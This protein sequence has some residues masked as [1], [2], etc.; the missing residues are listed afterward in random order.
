M[1]EFYRK[2]YEKPRKDIHAD[3][4]DTMKWLSYAYKGFF[5]GIGLSVLACIGYGACDTAYRKSTKT[6]FP[7]VY[8]VLSFHF[9]DDT[10]TTYEEKVVTIKAREF[11]SAFMEDNDK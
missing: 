10:P 6:T 9:G 7:F 11:K 5:L 3:D 8:W 1:K 2:T 4:T